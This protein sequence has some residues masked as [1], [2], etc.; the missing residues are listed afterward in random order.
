[1]LDRPL[2][3]DASTIWLKLKPLSINAQNL[4]IIALVGAGDVDAAKLAIDAQ[5]ADQNIDDYIK[6]LALIRQSNK[7]SGFAIAK[8]MAEKYSDSAQTQVSAAYVAQQFEQFE[9][10]EQWADKSLKIRPDWD[11]AA[12]VT[13]NILNVQGKLE[14]RAAFVAQFVADNP[15]SVSMRISLASELGRTEQFAEAYAL[16]V[17]VLNDDPNNV[18][19]LEYAAAL[20][21]RL[22]DNKLSAKHLQKA[23]SVEPEND[24]VRWSLARLAVIDQKYVT[25]ERLFDEITNEAMYVRAQIQVANMRAETQGR[26]G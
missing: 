8:Y 10:A 26:C 17:E 14:E 23:L 12:Q 9:S 2:A 7:E 13:V 19:A 6:Q 11:L 22:D 15:K 24:D 3:V 1:L 25:A 4:N 21:E 20:A 5:I 18:S 16:T